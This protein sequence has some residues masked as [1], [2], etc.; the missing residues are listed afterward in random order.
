[1]ARQLVGLLLVACSA[2]PA[3]ADSWS[4]MSLPDLVGYSDLIV[5]GT[6]DQTGPPCRVKV[7]EVLA[8]NAGDEVLIPQTRFG[9]PRAGERAVLFLRGH[10]EKVFLFH[11]SAKADVTV[12]D[13]V[14]RLLD[15]RAAPAKYLADPKTATSSDFVAMMGYAFAT[16][17]KIGALD[18][19]AVADH[20][21]RILSSAD[22]ETASRVLAALRQI[23]S[24]DAAAVLHLLKRPEANVRREAIQYLG[25]TAD[26]TAVGPLCELLDGITGYSELEAPIGRALIEMNDPVAVPALERAARRGVYGATSW[27]LGRLGTKRSFEIL[28]EGVEKKDAGDA[29]VGLEV[30]V[31]R[32][33]KRFEPWM[34]V[35]QWS[36]ETGMKHK[37]DWRKWWDA[38]KADFEVVKTAQ[39]AFRSD[40]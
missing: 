8:G 35:G 34:R 32:S 19:P 37:E 3:R 14:R 18:R 27:A 4:S 23:G 12:A 10:G 24:K 38:N 1:M 22:A 25:W 26:R 29:G 30:L 21:R 5:V 13:Q 6:I 16:R 28:L 17:D 7:T 2:V 15:M 39:E 40:R 36:S 20:L 31:R 9:L 33:N 11:P